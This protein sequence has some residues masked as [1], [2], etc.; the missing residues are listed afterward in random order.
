MARGISQEVNTFYRT[1]TAY[2]YS[3]NGSERT[4]CNGPYSIESMAKR[5]LV[6]PTPE[7]QREGRWRIVVSSHVEKLSGTWEPI[8]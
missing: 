7:D 3:S 8:A 6:K 4:E 5:M 2:R 1:V